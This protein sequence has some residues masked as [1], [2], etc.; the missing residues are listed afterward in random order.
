VAKVPENIFIPDLGSITVDH[1]G[2]VFVFAGRNMSKECSVLKFDKNLDFLKQFGRSGRG[3]GEF[4]TYG[5]LIQDRLTVDTNGDIFVIDYN[6]LKLVV[7][8]NDGNYKEDIPFQRNYSESIGFIRKIRIVGNGIFIGKKSLGNQP[9]IGVIFTLDP[10]GI[11][12][13]YPFNEVR[14]D[15]RIGNMM[16]IGVAKYYY[17]D[18]HFIE[19]DSEHIIF[20]N[21]QIYRFHVYDKVGNKILEIMEK[22]KI[23]GSFTDKELKKIRETEL[24]SKG[25][26]TALF[27]K[28]MEQVKNRKNVIADIKLSGQKIYVFP[29]REDITVDGKYPVEIYNLK[30]KIIKK[31]FVERPPDKIWKNYAFFRGRDEEDNPIILKYKI[32]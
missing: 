14:I 25:G 20:G 16:I 28:F 11:K 10:P 21:S 17:G 31:G 7:F 8:D 12:V 9:P 13:R 22:N 2:N 23:M 27:K 4:T 29:V 32:D 18:N 26:N 5:S 3:P 30:G 1:K 24:K 6:P 15:V 19:T